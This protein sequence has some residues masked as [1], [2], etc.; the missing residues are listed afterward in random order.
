MWNNLQIDILVAEADGPTQKPPT[1][2]DS[3]DCF[4]YGFLN[5]PL[6]AS[7]LSYPNN[8]FRHYDNSE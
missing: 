6:C 4:L 5:K 2:H 8:M 3:E 7:F 1:A